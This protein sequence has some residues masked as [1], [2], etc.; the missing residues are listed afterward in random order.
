MS[1]I[2]REWVQSQSQRSSTVE[3]AMVMAERVGGSFMRAL[4]V[5]WF[6]ADAVNRQKIE[7]GWQDEI[8]K[9][10]ALAAAQK[11]AS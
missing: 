10:R 7:A 1:A 9:Y 4:A 11:G 8:H 2:H 6:R 3:E 5:A